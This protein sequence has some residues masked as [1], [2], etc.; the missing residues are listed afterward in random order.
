[1]PI[2]V[3]SL[4]RLALQEAGGQAFSSPSGSWGFEVGGWKM[5]A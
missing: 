1:M 2:L 4:L 3:G 5:K